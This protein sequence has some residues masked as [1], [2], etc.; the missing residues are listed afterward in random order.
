MTL[1]MPNSEDRSSRLPNGVLRFL[2]TPPRAALCEQAHAYR[3]GQAIQRFRVATAAQ[4]GI[5]IG[6][7]FIV[8]EAVF[9]RE[10]EGAQHRAKAVEGLPT[11]LSQAGGIGV[12]RAGISRHGD[13]GARHQ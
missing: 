5:A 3:A 1:A 9:V 7:M 2:K 10:V 11:D 8:A 12:E 6:S 4:E 13:V